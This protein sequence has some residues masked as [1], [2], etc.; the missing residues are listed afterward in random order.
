VDAFIETPLL[1][2]RNSIEFEA[3]TET[4]PIRCIL[5]TGSTG[6]MLNKDMQGGFNNHMIFNPDTIDQHE[7]LNPLNSDQMQFD[8]EDICDMPLL[9]IGGKDFGTVKFRK[10]KSPFEIDAIIG[11][12]FLDSKLVFIDF[13]NRKIYFYKK[14]SD[15]SDECVQSSP[16]RIP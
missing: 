15:P 4:G 10:M 9:K 2:D 5:D 11:M 12:D 16:Q 14:K 7:R 1:L 8:I 3:M 13:P 6:N